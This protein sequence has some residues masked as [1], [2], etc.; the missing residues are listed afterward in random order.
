MKTILTLY[1]YKI[2]A[3]KEIITNNKHLKR[4]NMETQKTSIAARNHGEISQHLTKA[5]AGP[6]CPTKREESG[7]KTIYGHAGKRLV[8]EVY[9][10]QNPEMAMKYLEFVIKNPWV[11]YIRWDREEKRF[12]AAR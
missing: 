6:S 2:L 7:L 3:I 4:I 10:R 5:S 9:A 11:Q 8:Y 12:L 1:Q